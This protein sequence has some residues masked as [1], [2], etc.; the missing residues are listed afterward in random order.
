MRR[1]LLLRHAKA[2]RSEPGTKDISRVLIDRGRKDAAKIGAYMAA[3]ALVPDR[4]ILSPSARTQETWKY[5]AAAFHPAPAATSAERIYDAPPHTILAV[6]KDTP[7]SAHTLMVI[8]H[9]P[10]LH[11]LALMLVAAGGIDARERLREK[12]PTSG[13]VIIDFAVDNWSKLQPQSGRLERFVNPK[14]L[15][16]TAN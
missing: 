6:I 13:L 2:E 1:L 9:N 15:E 4:V 8:G 14:T 11:E 3:H 16:A 12:L 5:A 10:G 7:A